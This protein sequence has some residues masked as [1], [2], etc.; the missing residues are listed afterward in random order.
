MEPLNS[1]D[2]MLEIWDNEQGWLP[3]TEAYLTEATEL[4]GSIVFQLLLHP[5]YML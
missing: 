1:G 3:L 4:S 5:F 2:N